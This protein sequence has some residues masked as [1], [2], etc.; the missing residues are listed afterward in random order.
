VTLVATTTKHALQGTCTACRLAQ[1]PHSGPAPV[2][3]VQKCHETSVKPNCGR[4]ANLLPQL[5]AACIECM[6]TVRN[7]HLQ[8]L[9]LVF[10]QSCHVSIS[11][12]LITLWVG[13]AHRGDLARLQPR[14]WVTGCATN[15]LQPTTCCDSPTAE[16]LQQST[17]SM[18]FSS[19]GLRDS[20]LLGLT[21]QL[22][23]VV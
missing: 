3:G 2:T 4:D 5:K 22:S 7:T 15:K 10:Q 11:Q 8:Q 17:A 21:P 23:V 20:Q 6:H 9:W 1:A 13:A 19:Q 16:S 14:G 18:H 12:L